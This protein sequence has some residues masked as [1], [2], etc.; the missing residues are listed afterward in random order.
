MIKA[1]SYNLSALFSQVFFDLKKFLE[2]SK[3]IVPPELARHEAAKVKPGG[4]D[5]RPKRDIVFSNK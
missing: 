1:L 4:V 5:A 3:M 2:E